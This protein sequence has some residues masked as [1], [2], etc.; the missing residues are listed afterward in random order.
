[1][2]NIIEKVV[3]FCY[4]NQ[5]DFIIQNFLFIAENEWIPVAPKKPET[6]KQFIPATVSTESF[7]I[8][9]S[10]TSIYPVQSAVFSHSIAAEV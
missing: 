6:K 10:T 1:M 4:Y 2:D 8:T 9:P 5:N 3:M 7:P